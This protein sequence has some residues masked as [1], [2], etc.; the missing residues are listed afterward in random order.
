MSHGASL[1]G[2][3]QAAD[4]WANN[5][6]NP[7]R[8]R[9]SRLAVEV[10][11]FRDLEERAGDDLELARVFR[12]AR[13]LAEDLQAARRRFCADAPP[14]TFIESELV[15]LERLSPWG[16]DPEFDAHAYVAALRARATPLDRA[17]AAYLR[18]LAAAHEAY[19]AVFKEA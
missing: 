11:T 17:R 14:G 10:E 18:D 6:L 5:P 19:A 2:D 8:I 12:A 15:F 7:H 13:R 16:G 3:P 4:D 1:H 9:D